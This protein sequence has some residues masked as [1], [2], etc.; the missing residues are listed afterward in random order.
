MNPTTTILSLVAAALAG[1]TVVTFNDADVAKKDVINA[2]EES[3]VA[4]RASGAKIAAAERKTFEAAERAKAALASEAA[5][6]EAAKATVDGSKKTS[7][8]LTKALAELKT[9]ATKIA[10]LEKARSEAAARINET[11]AEV[12]KLRDGSDLRTAQAKAKKAEGDL[13]QASIALR[14]TNAKLDEV[15]KKLAVLEEENARIKADAKGFD[16]P[17]PNYRAR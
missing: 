17:S 1:I 16:N 12:A 3:L 11:N 8:D 4:I 14:D 6:K 9:S 10:E 5:A 7:E 15:S 13:E 2:K